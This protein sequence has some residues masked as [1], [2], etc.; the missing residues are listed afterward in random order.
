LFSKILITQKTLHRYARIFA[1][2][3][4]LILESCNNVIVEH[5]VKSLAEPLNHW[6]C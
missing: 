5:W 1:N 2:F 6:M 3:R 4:K